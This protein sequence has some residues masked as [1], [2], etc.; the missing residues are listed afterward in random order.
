MAY[1]TSN[2]VTIKSLCILK[3]KLVGSVGRQLSEL[4]QVRITDILPKIY[5]KLSEDFPKNFS[6][7]CVNVF[8]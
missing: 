1:W 4:I 3:D 8:H 5:G 2:S 6:N 7:F